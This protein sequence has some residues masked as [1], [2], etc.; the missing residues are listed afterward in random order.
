VG[1][2]WEWLYGNWKGEVGVRGGVTGEEDAD[3]LKWN[4]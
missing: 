3:W 2:D 1:A 4:C